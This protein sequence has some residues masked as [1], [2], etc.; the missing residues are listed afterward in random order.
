M[1]NQFR[2]RLAEKAILGMAQKRPGKRN[3]IPVKDAR[4]IGIMYD[5]G[6]DGEVSIREL[7][8]KP[9]LQGKQISLLAYK[10]YKPAK[11]EPAADHAFSVRD[12]NWLYQPKVQ[13]VNSFLQQDFDLLIDLTTRDY[14]PLLYILAQSPSS[15][16]AS[17]FSEKKKQVADLMI[18]MNGDPD[19][20][21][22]FQQ[23]DHYITQ[24]N[25]AQ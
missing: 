15:L 25:Q 18:Q 12:V 20:A 19:P 13:V 6:R 22:L 23:I 9:S 16:N 21:S 2:Q 10:P 11:G 24:L 1:L 3:M 5:W 4:H 17:I 7:L 14:Y 8:K